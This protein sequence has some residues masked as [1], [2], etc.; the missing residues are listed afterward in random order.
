MKTAQKTLTI[1]LL[2]TIASISW[3]GPPRMKGRS[4]GS[5]KSSFNRGFSGGKSFPK[6][7]GSSGSPK[8][9]SGGNFSNRSISPRNFNQAKTF[10]SPAARGR[11]TQQ[12]V[13][14]GFSKSLG[15]KSLKR[16]TPQLGNFKARNIKTNNL[17][18]LGFEKPIQKGSI[19]PGIIK[20]GVI[21][22]G[23]IKPG[24]IKPG[25]IKPG[26]IKPGVIKPGIIKPGIIKPGVIKPGVIKPGVIK[27]GVI[28][29][30]IIKPGVIKPGVIKPGVIKPGIIKPGVIKPGVIKPGIIKPG[31]IKPGVIKPGIVNPGGLVP[32]PGNAGKPKKPWISWGLHFHLHRP[33]CTPPIVTC[34]PPAIC[35]PSVLAVCPTAEVLVIERAPEQVLVEHLENPPAEPGFVL[36]LESDTEVS[37]EIDGL[38]GIPGALV[39]DINGLGLPVAVLGMEEGVVQIRVPSVGLSEAQLGKLYV[40]NSDMKLIAGVDARLNPNTGG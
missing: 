32:H 20:P 19:K 5:G 30:G 40:L 10:K 31:I 7:R 17:K 34:P 18:K 21:K 8:L 35:P 1:V 23:I 39:L 11:M 25:V 28:K 15:T 4:M 27:P 24:V 14:S 2:F 33:L 29:P 16:N 9:G 6:G 37:L 26:V 22:P 38:D 12:K 3:A 36:D 13:S